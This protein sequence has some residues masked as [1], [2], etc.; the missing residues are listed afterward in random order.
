PPRYR[1]VSPTP[2]WRRLLL[3]MPTPPCATWSSGCEAADEA[4]RLGDPAPGRCR[5]APPGRPGFFPYRR[6]A[7]GPLPARRDLRGLRLG[8]P[9]PRSGEAA[10]PRVG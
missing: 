6:G 5:A 7:D 1:P 3:R 10:A 4:D 9:R 2:P 8:N